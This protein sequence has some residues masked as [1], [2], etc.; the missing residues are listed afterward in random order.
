MSDRRLD[1]AIDRAVRDMMSVEATP[2]MR[3]R[4]LARLESRTRP[5]LGFRIGAVTS[6]AAAALAVFML[7]W[8]RDTEPVR[9]AA[10][11]SARAPIVAVESQSAPAPP[12]EDRAPAA[13]RAAIVRAPGTRTVA[14]AHVETDDPLPRE[15]DP[16]ATLDPIVIDPIEHTSIGP[17]E[18]A[19]RPLAP[20]REVHVEPLIP[21]GERD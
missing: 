17:S 13:P 20:I 2:G 1:D 7:V 18:L 21:R 10:D 9:Q 16:L 6:L 8:M 19:L 4:V 14:A 12:P 11:E 15:I 5:A 3:A